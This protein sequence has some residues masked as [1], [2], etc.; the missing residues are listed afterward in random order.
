MK[1]TLFAYLFAFVL[2]CLL[3]TDSNAMRIKREKPAELEGSGE[4]SGE[5]LAHA[6]KM[7]LFAA[8]SHDALNATEE[9]SGSS[10]EI[11]EACY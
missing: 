3:I 11:S 10:A 4:G 7:N 9:G 6:E 8:H 1:A 2:L 5:E